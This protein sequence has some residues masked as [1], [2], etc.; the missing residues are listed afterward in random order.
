MTEARNLDLP[1][2][3]LTRLTRRLTNPFRRRTIPPQPLQQPPTEER[4]NFLRS[5]MTKEEYLKRLPEVDQ[6]N[7]LHLV[8]RISAIFGEQGEK[9][10]MYA[11]G[12]TVSKE[13]RRKDIDTLLVLE[14]KEELERKVNE[15]PLDYATRDF[16]HIQG[17]LARLIDEE[18]S[19]FS[20]ITPAPPLENEE[21]GGGLILRH[22]GGFKIVPKNGGVPIEIIR[23]SNRANHEEYM[24]GE[25]RP[26]VLLSEF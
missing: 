3:P 2:S 23:G 1:Q 6:D 8:Q 18:N 9:G 25:K 13:G 19:P 24:T 4:Q 7:L 11:V 14:P 17:V 15:T 21:Y 16:E 20:E 10:A 22:D 12:G 5:S 26:S